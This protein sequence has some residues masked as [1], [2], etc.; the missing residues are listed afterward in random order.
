M[1]YTL[2]I[3]YITL[4]NYHGYQENL[5]PMKINN[6]YI[7]YSFNTYTIININI[8]YNWPAFLAA[9]WLNNGY[10]SSYALIRMCY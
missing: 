9:S 4:R 3:M 10:T 8:P 5:I 1:S 6:H 7:P 2:N